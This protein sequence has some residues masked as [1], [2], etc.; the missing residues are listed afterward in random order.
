MGRPCC[1]VGG[2]GGQVGKLIEGAGLRPLCQTTPLPIDV[3]TILAIIFACNTQ[4]K[5]LNADT[6]RLTRICI[7]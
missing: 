7:G 6:A 1:M 4:P 3:R 5:P 2:K